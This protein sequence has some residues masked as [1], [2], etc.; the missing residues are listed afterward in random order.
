MND[1]FD[2]SRLYNEIKITFHVHLPE[3]IEKRGQPV[4]L[5]SRKELGSWETP[6]VKL[7]QQNQTY[8]KSDPITI[9][10]LHL[11]FLRVTHVDPIHYKYAIYISKSM[12][13]RGNEKFVFEGID[14]NFKDCRM[15]NI[16]RND[17]FDIWMNNHQY[18]SYVIR[19][20]AFVDCIYNSIKGDNLKDQVMK[21]QYLLFIHNDLTIRASNLDFIHNHIDDKFKEKRLFLCLLLGYYI[22]R[23]KGTFHELPVDFQSKL[24]LSAL[25]GYK[26]ETLLSNTK[27]LMYTAIITLVCHNAFQMQFDWP[28]IFTISAEIDPSYSF[29]DKLKTLKYSDKNLAKFVETIGPYIENIGSRAYVKVAKWLILL[30]HNTD[31][32]LK[33]W[34]D[35]LLRNIKIDKT[36]FRCYIEQIQKNISH[37]ND[38]AVALES[39]FMKLPINYRY[40]L[41]E[42]F[43]SRTLFLLEDPSREWTKGNIAAI[44]RLLHSLNWHGE[45]VIKSLELISKSHTLELLN[46]FPDLLDN[47]FR[48]DFSDKEKKIP[49]ICTTWIKNLSSRLYKSTV[50]GRSLDESKFIFLIF[51]QLE[52]IHPLL[53]YRINIWQGLTDTAIKIVKECS[54]IQIFAA[55]ILIVN[56]DQDEVKVLF[57]N[58][59]KEILNKTVLQAD[60]E[61]LHNIFI[62]CFHKGEILKVPN[63]MSEDILY[64]IITILQNQSSVFTSSQHHLNILKSSKFWNIILHA[65][66]SVAKLNSHPFIKRVRDSI[67]ELSLLFVEKMIDVQLLQQLLELPDKKLVRHFCSAAKMGFLDFFQEVIVTRD[68]IA[69]IRKLYDDYRSRLDILLNFYTGLCPIA[70][71]T[72]VDDYIRDVKQHTTNLDKVEVKQV[73]APDYLSFHEKTLVSAKRCYKFR[74]SQT[75][76]N[77]FETCIKE[78]AAATKV[79]YV[80]QILIPIVFEKYS[81]LC[82]QLEEWE[83]LKCS[84]AYLLWKNVKDVNL[85]LDLMD[86]YN[87]DKSEELLIALDNFSKWIEQLENLE[88]VVVIFGVQHDDDDWLSKSIRNLKDDSMELEKTNNLFDYLNKNLIKVNQN[89]WKLIKELSQADDLIEFLKKVNNH[90]I[91]N[92]F[93]DANDH[94]DEKLIQI[95]LLVHVNQFLFPLLNN[96]KTITDFL[97]EL[98]HIIEKDHTLG[99][100]VSSCNSNNAMFQNMYNNIQ[101]RD[102]ST[103]EKIK[104]AVLNGTYTFTRDEEKGSCLV[105]LEYLSESNVMYNLNEILDLRRRALL[106][107]ESIIKII[108]D[109]DEEVSK[110]VVDEFIH[111]VDVVQ[112]IS[113]TASMLMQIGHF[114]YR[115]FEKKLQGTDNMEDY[116]N[117]LKDELERWQVMLDHAHKR[118]YYLTFFYSYHILSFYDYFTSE[119]LDKKNEEECKTLIRFVNSKAQL[120]SHEDVQGILHGLKDHFEIL[121]EIGNELEKIFRNIPKQWRKLKGAEQLDLITKGKLF[122]AAYIDKIQV[123]NMIMKL[124]AN[125]GY[126]PEPW[127]I[128]ICTSTTTMEELTIFI[129]RCFFASN[130]GYKNHLFCIVNLELLEFELQC[131]FIKYIRAMQLEYKNENYLLTF[132]CYRKSEMSNNI[133]DQFSLEARE[134]NGFDTEITGITQEVYQELFTHVT[135][136][137]SDLSGQGKTEWIKETSHSKQKIPLGF[138]ISDN[139]DLKYLVNKLKSCKLKQ[140]QSLHINILSTDYPEEVNLFLFE[141]LTF[142]LVSYNNIIVSIPDI[143]IFIEISSSIKQN[144]LI[145]LPILRCSHHKYLN[146]NIEN[147]RVSQEITNP[148]QIICHFLKLYDLEIEENLFHDIKRPLPEEFCQH[149][150][151]KYFLNKSGKFILSFKYIEIFANILMDQ[152]IRFCSS[153]YFTINN[154]KLSLKEA[155]IGSTIIKSLLST[156]KDF[157]IQSIKAKSAQ[158]K[159]LTSV[160]E[161]KIEKFDNLLYNIYFFN[162]HTSNSYILYNDKN[163]VPDN[164][165]LL[166][167]GQEL[168]DY[169]TMATTEL[170]VKLETVA[171]SS[172]EKLNLPEY[173]LTVDNLMKIVL[174]LLRVRA[175]IPVVICGEV[176]CGKTCLITYLARIVEVQFYTLNLHA[177][178]DEETIMIFM[179]DALKK[180]EKDETWILFDEIN[181]CNHLGLLAEVISNRKFMDEPIHSNVRL[182]ATCNPYR[183]HTRVQSEEN[184]DKKCDENKINLIY[185]V[186][187]LPDKILDYVW[188]LDVIKSNDERRYIQSMVEIELKNDLADPVFPELLFASQTFIRKVEESYSVSLRDI[189]RAITLVKFFY[190]SLENRPAN[191]KGQKYPPSGNPTIITRSYILAL[192]ICYHSRLHN[193]ELHKQYRC[194]IE[195]ILRNHEIY[196][197]ENMFSKII[198]EEQEDYINRMQF[199]Q[200][201]VKNEALLENVLVTIICILTRIPVFIIGETGSSK[202][203]AIRIINSNLCGTD[204]DDE[205][206]KS[207]PQIR[208]FPQQVSLSTTSNDIIKVFNK[209]NEYQGTTSKKS[210]VISVVLLENIELAEASF[211]NPLKILHSL[212]EPNCPAIW[213]TVSVVGISNYRLDISKSNRAILV[214]RPQFDMDNLISVTSCLLGTKSTGLKSIVKA[215]LNYEKHGQKLPNFHG[216]RDYYALVKQLLT[217]EVTPDGIQMALARNFGGIENSDKLCEKYFGDV[218]KNFNNDNS[219]S[220]KQISIEKLID[221]NLDDPNA[222]YLMVIGKSDSIVNLLTYQLKRKDL[223]PV[224]ILGS[225]FPNDQDDY[226]YSVLTK[227]IM[228]IK[229]GRPLI[230]TDLKMIYGNLY[231]L[232]NRNY[233]IVEN[234]GSAKYFTNITLGA[235]ENSTLFVPSSFKCFLV[236]D[237]MELPLADSS[238]LSRF[239]KQKMSIDNILND[240]QMLIV[241]DLFIWINKM[242]TSFESTPDIQT[243]NKFI[244]KDLFIG[245]DDDETLQSLVINIIK[246]NPEAE[247]EVIL[248]KC[249]ECLIAIASPDGIIRAELSTLERD[250]FNKWKHVYFHQQYHDSLYDYFSALLNQEKSFAGLKEHLIIVSTFSKI[251]VDIKICLQ[252]LSGYQVYNLSIF[253]TESQFSNMVKRFFFESTDQ[254][255]I[256]QCDIKTINTKCVKLVKHIIERF[257]NEFLTKNKQ[258]ETNIPI[259][260]I[261]S[262]C[263]ILHIQQDYESNSLLSNFICGWKRIFI[264]SL[265]SPEIPLIDLLDKSLYEIIN[266]KLFEMIIHS[267]TPFEKILQ[268]ELS[269]CLSCIEYQHSNEGCENYVSSLSKKI[270]NSSNFIQCIKTKTYEWILTNCKNWQCEVA[271][272]KNLS[273]Y[274]CFSLSLRKYVIVI[275]KQTISKI[276]YSLEKLSAMSTFFNNEN[277]KSNVKKELSDLWIKFFMDNA[278]INIDNL[279]EP[280]PSMYIMSRLIND[281]EFPFSYYFINLINYY[282]KYYYEELDILKQDSE[283]FNNEMYEDHIEDFKNNLITIHP[284]FEYL[285]KYSEFYYN[286]FIRIILSTYSIKLTSKENLDFILRHLIG[287][288]EDKIIDPFILHIYWWKYANE[289]LIQL[290]LVETFPN[291]ITK[292]QNDFIIHGKLDQYLFREAVNCILQNI[293]DD[294]PWKQDMDYILSILSEIKEIDDDSGNFSNLNLLFVCDDLLKINSIPLEKIKEIIY[295]GKSAKKQEFITSE[296]IN[297]VFSSSDDSNNDIIPIISFIKKSLK[298]IPLESEIRLILYRNIFSQSPFNL[299]N[300]IIEKVFITESQQNNQ[301]FFTLIEKNSEESLQNSIRLE[302]IN[303]N[304]KNIDSKMAELCCNVIQRIFSKFELNELSPYFKHAIKSFVQ[305]D[306]LLNQIFILQQITSIALLKEFI[307]KFW[308]NYFQEDNSLSMSLIEEIKD[309]LKINNHPIIQFIQSY[310]VIDL[311]SFDNVNRLEIIKEEITW[312]DNFTDT[313]TNYLTN[314]LKP[315]KKLN[316]EDLYTFNNNNLDKNSFL[317]IFLKYHK[318]LEFIKHLYPIIRFVKILNFKLEYHLTRKEAQTMTFHEFI[319]KESADDSEYAN[320]KSLFEEFAISWNSII[321][322]I[323]QYQSKELLNKPHMNLEI[324]VIFGLIEQKDSGIYLCAIVD[325][326][327]KLHNEFLD[328][329]IGIPIGKCEYLKFLEDSSWNKLTPKTY[330]IMSKKADQ[331][332]D[333]NFINYEWN[334][335]IFKYNQKNLE[336]NNDINFIFDLQKIEMKLAKKL[337]YNKVYFEMEDNQFYLKNFSFKYELFYNFPRILFDIKNILPQK[338]IPEDKR[339]ITLALLDPTKSLYNSSN[340]ID[341]P[342]LYSLF[343]TILCFVKELSIKNNNILILDLIE[344]WLKLARYSNVIFIDI[345]KEFSLKH[346]VA[347]YELIEERVANSIIHNIEEKFKIPLTQQMKD[348]INNVINYNQNQQLIPAKTFAFALKRFIYRFLLVDFNIENEN[349]NTYF[350]DFTL[351]LW[352]DVNEESIEK[353]FPSCLL[354]S[355]AYNAYNF[356]IDEIEKNEKQ[357]NIS[358]PLIA[359]RTNLKNKK[360]KKYTG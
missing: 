118:C 179:E 96:A 41:S 174:I 125:Y 127:Q 17:Q 32:L 222:R 97:G 311:N 208:L 23:E 337:I 254:I 104:N 7:R 116:R 133:L 52:Y 110:N 145:N 303:D 191:K 274:T 188:D 131:N 107:D 249:K 8:W 75:F 138:L 356:I 291:I 242:L 306:L 360:P 181:T 248:E 158:F 214:Q 5:G 241:K 316:F 74:Q 259:K 81:T 162:S 130:N 281:L 321:S 63:S 92:L 298:L 322:H 120:P 152:L 260:H 211:L 53:G 113:N 26:Q 345:L 39:R 270:L 46:I 354:V 326:L 15:L 2:G 137:S 167:N 315:I 213:P 197:E 186:K 135:C 156:S 290:K 319:K 173:A 347:F 205:Y 19:D 289:I 302:N 172:N 288:T 189:K 314:L 280:K 269:W 10:F 171:R 309:V 264:E 263:L 294:K 71:V 286:D 73:L 262:A 297:L 134:I 284:D 231:D 126:Y 115:K 305:E 93:N 336:I 70:Q 247:A 84:E 351:N 237:E 348:S 349:L 320:L 100:K 246:N 327:I 312:L 317:S 276:L 295:L 149:L 11:H 190:N 255:L 86:D 293:Y 333:N 98:L 265:E 233:V 244:E 258:F 176:G 200:N 85:E 36:I 215:Y 102:K 16:E 94:S 251:N 195:Q 256:L 245:F 344:H 232:W 122:V 42:V 33:L 108:T 48:G 67:N 324:P 18:S 299:M 111:Q 22:S 4:V 56:L 277:D 180:A 285:Q 212:I 68:E 54:E 338:S 278:I 20:F 151:M 14:G 170:L 193:Q 202:S 160:H 182:F 282:E 240:R 3:G 106:I 58:L 27:D 24:L 204:S 109:N 359:R 257:Q 313:K 308:K 12:F 352:N 357:N 29:I 335:K 146:W 157:I 79:E 229:T 64:H 196:V 169:N 287:V 80:A 323:N 331:A 13:N 90:D 6:I 129:K 72:D 184:K 218:I 45:E 304:I 77:I 89:C 95:S 51:Q 267:T 183:R 216:L 140:T 250:E 175:S 38:D 139:M 219:W 155:N 252:D 164:I 199:P 143:F 88:K 275:I 144:L 272:N 83:K 30:C 105:S 236:M 25:E 325:F 328:N 112:E 177:G 301:I 57:L 150:I 207:L 198:R 161:N 60:D 21:Y 66:G 310:F 342:E 148:V 355:H 224:I 121:C 154:L 210:P 165:K 31:S 35:V 201:I 101:N 147:L 59:V 123:P 203:L 235:C 239:E 271:L 55:T 234:D 332:Q 99:E 343:E 330:F 206:F 47:W 78:V 268:N 91:K 28:I 65:D 159:Y 69:K 228:C 141:L 334:D 192:S 340:S 103:K 223:D 307:N 82:K 283:N 44:E 114:C 124:Y 187:P 43:Q 194:E 136:V 230:L 261:K 178:I 273:E 40:D 226:F 353:L 9:S 221:S 61:L 168:E 253:K 300:S 166:L 339:L 34:S 49:N 217:E 142:K 346:V 329:I 87:I 37:D 341:L 163:E 318:N 132:L 153:Q 227:I 292:A 119:S 50:N 62:I 209:A 243:H 266:S 185:Q 220:C 358:A 350:L 128:L 296:I 238:L 225:Q 279:C 76:R 117:F 1:W